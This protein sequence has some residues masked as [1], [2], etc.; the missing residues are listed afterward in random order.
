M[1]GNWR[2][3]RVEYLIVDFEMTMDSVICVELHLNADDADSFHFLLVSLTD[4]VKTG[5]TS[6]FT[7]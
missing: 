1:P 6:W 4:I 2:F 5:S 7:K 3:R